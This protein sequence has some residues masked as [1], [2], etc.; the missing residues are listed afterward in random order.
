MEKRNLDRLT[1]TAANI[2]G[3]LLGNRVIGTS[4]L[5]EKGNCYDLSSVSHSIL[6]YAENES[7]TGY[8]ELTYPSCV[9]LI[10]KFATVYD[11]NEV[12]IYDIGAYDHP[13]ANEDIDYK[14]LNR[15]LN[16]AIRTQLAQPAAI[17]N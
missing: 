11:N 6:K 17:G 1:I 10:I 13:W 9:R 5:S 2:A 12:F 15:Q 7:L 4:V 8:L 14:E 3:V 16:I